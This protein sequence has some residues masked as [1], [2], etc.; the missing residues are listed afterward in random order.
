MEYISQKI[1][2]GLCVIRKIK[3]FLNQKS[4]LILYHCLI[5]SRVMY[6]ISVW[7][8]RNK[9]II[10]KL[11]RTLNKF[12]RLTFSV[13]SRGSVSEIMKKFNLLT[14]KQMVFKETVLFM[15]K[16]HTKLHPPVFYNFFRTKQNMNCEVNT[17]SNSS[18]TPSFCRL[19]QLH[20]NPFVIRDLLCGMNFLPCHA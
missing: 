19:Y 8:H 10:N 9:T 13:D 20:N 4:L 6:C 3:P 15:F 18:L 1:R 14:I 12:I 5:V 7:C 17:R 2:N 16:F 11:Q